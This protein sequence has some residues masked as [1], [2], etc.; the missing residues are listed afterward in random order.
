M[1]LVLYTVLTGNYDS[2]KQP[3]LIDTRFDY[4]CF[5]N[6]ISESNVGIW[7]IR[8]IPGTFPSKQIESRYPKMH[9]HV[10]LK[11]YDYSVYVDANIQIKNEIFYE[12]VLKKIESKTL[13]AGVKHP[14]RNCA[15][16]EAYVVFSYGLEKSPITII[17]E[18]RFLKHEKFP[19]KYGMFEANII[20]RNHHSEKIIAQ[21]EEWWNMINKYSKRDQLSYSYTLWKHGIPFDYLLPEN[22]SARDFEGVNFYSHP[23]EKN[24]WGKQLKKIGR[25]I[26]RFIIKFALNKR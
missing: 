21:C 3:E 18:M 8:K 7:K 24:I 5:S 14:F 17:R 11:D 15:Y 13:L 10:L 23:R 4:I 26:Y 12:H 1:K 9:P 25:K 6:D 20:L 19:E 2:L 22:V 16:D